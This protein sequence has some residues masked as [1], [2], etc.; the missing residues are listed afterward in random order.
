[1]PE[2]SPKNE[3]KKSDHQNKRNGLKAATEQDFSGIRFAYYTSHYENIG[4]IRYLLL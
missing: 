4:V 2:K 3:F 1:L